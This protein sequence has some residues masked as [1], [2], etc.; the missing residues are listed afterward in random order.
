VRVRDYTG[1]VRFEVLRAVDVEVRRSELKR[2]YY[3]AARR[4]KDS[5]GNGATLQKPELR[6]WRTVMGGLNARARAEA[7]AAAYRKLYSSRPDLTEPP[8]GEPAGGNTDTQQKKDKDK[9]GE[10]KKTDWRKKL[11]LEP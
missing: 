5:S 11:G 3:E 10:Q 2:D 1:H 4:S 9:D 8:A 7:A 6:V